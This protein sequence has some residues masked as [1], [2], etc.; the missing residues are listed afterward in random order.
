MPTV[1]FSLITIDG[2]TVE[3]WEW[4]DAH[5]LSSVMAMAGCPQPLLRARCTD[6][7]TEILCIGEKRSHGESAVEIGTQQHAFRNQGADQEIGTQQ[8]AFRNQGAN[9]SPARGYQ[10]QETNSKTS[11]GANA[12]RTQWG[13]AM[14]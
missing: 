14:R 8:H 4:P 9:P 3:R 11:K 2:G 6:A 5:N 1:Y 7:T 13:S 10:T 12:F